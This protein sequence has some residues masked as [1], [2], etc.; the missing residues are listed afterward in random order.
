MVVADDASFLPSFEP[1]GHEVPFG[2][3]HGVPFELGGVRMAGRIDR[4]ER[5]PAGVVAIDYKSSGAVKGVGSFDAHGLIQPTVYAAAASRVYGAPVAGGVYR[6]M[7]TL[8]VRG[9]WLR[10][11]IDLGDRGAASDAR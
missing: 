1:A 4:V 10:G 8:S 6:S 9:F 2:A 5:G 7:R 11:A 3:A